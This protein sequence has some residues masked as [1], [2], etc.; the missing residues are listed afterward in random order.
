MDGLIQLI[1]KIKNAK[2]VLG[3]VRDENLITKISKDAEVI[4]ILLL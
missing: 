1:K 3:D 4:I 2:I